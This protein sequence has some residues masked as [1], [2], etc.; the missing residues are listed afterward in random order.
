LSAPLR[1]VPAKQR[2]AELGAAFA[3]S[4][5]ER[6]AMSALGQK[7]TLRCGSTPHWAMSRARSDARAIHLRLRKVK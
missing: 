7:Q 1:L 5:D 4:S 3:K 2:R 6:P